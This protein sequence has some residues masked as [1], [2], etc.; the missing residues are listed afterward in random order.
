MRTP[1]GRAR[2]LRFVRRRLAFLAAASLSVPALAFAAAGDPKEAFTPA[3]QAKAKTL[4][5]VRSDFVAG[6]KRVPKAAE[7]EDVSC[8][9]FAPNLSDLTLTGEAETQFDHAATGASVFS[10]ASLYKTAAQARAGWS[11]SIRP[12]LIRCFVEVMRDAVGTGSTVTCPKQG[13]VAFPRVSAR[14]YALKLACVVAATGSD[15]KL[16]IALDLVVLG[17]GRAETSVMA[18]GMGAG[19]PAADLRSFARTLAARMQRAGV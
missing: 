12:A 6:W 7:D 4:V 5:L 8:A 3:D 10:Y 11:R 19:I 1:P 15:V 9:S 2:R 14:V 18:I 13:R 17:R 16:R